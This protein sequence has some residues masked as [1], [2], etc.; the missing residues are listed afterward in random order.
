M[1]E[2]DL[3]VSGARV[4]DPETGRDEVLS[5]G[6]SGGSI[7]AV[8]KNDLAGKRRINGEGL[9]LSPGFIDVHVHE[10][11]LGNPPAGVFRLPEKVAG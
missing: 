4:I 2:F 1:A 5:V 7:T 9:V 6:V 8:A 3:V 10:D 11:G